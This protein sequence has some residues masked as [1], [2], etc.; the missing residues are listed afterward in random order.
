MVRQGKTTGLDETQI[1]A[2]Q[3]AMTKH[4]GL[5]KAKAKAM[6][7]IDTNAPPGVL[8][9]CLGRCLGKECWSA[10]LVLIC[11]GGSDVRDRL[12]RAVRV[13]TDKAT[14]TELLAAYGGAGKRSL[15]DIACVV[16]FYVASEALSFA[17]GIASAVQPR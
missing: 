1:R 6:A 16:P 7:S 3:A 5:E 8:L 4:R 14:L 10:S 2:V 12:R 11:M 15:A 17:F 13:A 9:L